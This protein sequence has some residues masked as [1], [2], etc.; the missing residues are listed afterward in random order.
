[1]R[2]ITD[3]IINTK[4]KL[5]IAKFNRNGNAN[6][7]EPISQAITNTSSCITIVI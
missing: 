2:T 4:L 3:T 6:Y 7:N 1:M 5:Y